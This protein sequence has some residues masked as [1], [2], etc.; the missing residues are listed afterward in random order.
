[1]LTPRRAAFVI[2]GFA[3]AT[4]LGGCGGDTVQEALGYE[5]TGPDEMA[6]IKRPPL[7][8]PPDYNL[9]PPRPDDENLA[10]EAASETARQTLLGTSSSGDTASSKNEPEGSARAIL[11]G[12]GPGAGESASSIGSTPSDGQNLLVSRTNRVERDLDALTETR[13]ENRVDASLLRRLLAWTPADRP[14]TADDDAAADTD[15]A[16]DVDGAEEVV[17][18]VE[19]I[20]RSRTALG[21]S[22]APDDQKSAE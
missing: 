16:S 11:T 20:S 12:G 4:M 13:A 15:S 3:F 22:P 1:M 6:V 2:M 18:V 7:T 14:V 8:V 19:V 17:S 9:R 21:E 5:Q 10:E